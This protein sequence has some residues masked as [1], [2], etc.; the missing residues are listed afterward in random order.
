MFC[1]QSNSLL[2]NHCGG[3][4]KDSEGECGD[5]GPNARVKWTEWD[6][7]ITS[8]WLNKTIDEI[9][10]LTENGQRGLMMEVVAT[11]DIY[12]GEEVS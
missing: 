5:N 11:R 8:E 10:K 1:S 6:G 7:G 9:D 3:R 2:I 12:P 4:I